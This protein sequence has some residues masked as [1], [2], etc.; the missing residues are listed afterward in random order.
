[1]DLGEVGRDDVDWIGLAQDKN[2]WRAVVNS[3]L[4]LRVP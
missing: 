2:K 4:N 3:V 1:M